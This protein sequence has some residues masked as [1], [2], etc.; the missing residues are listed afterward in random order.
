MDLM[1]LNTRCLVYLLISPLKGII[2]GGGGDCQS[3]YIH[4][5][6]YA[7]NI[8]THAVLDTPSEIKTRTQLKISVLL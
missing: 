4:N 8:I 2:G 3:K 7:L 1:D 6:C 5:A